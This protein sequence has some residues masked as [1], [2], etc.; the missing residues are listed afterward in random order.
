MIELCKNVCKIK[1]FF[2]ELKFWNTNQIGGTFGPF[3][4]HTKCMQCSVE[5][6]SGIEINI[7]SLITIS[8][9]SNDRYA[10]INY[11]E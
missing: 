6:I 5:K 3:L 7:S 10:G 1:F 9:H 8:K 11:L 4:A 2:L